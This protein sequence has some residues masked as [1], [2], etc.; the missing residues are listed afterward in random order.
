MSRISRY[1]QVIQTFA[2]YGF[3]DLV[4]E[5]SLRNF[6]KRTKASK[7][8]NGK[9]GGSRAERIRLLL[10]ELGPTYVKLGQLLSNRRDILPEEWIKEL[11]HLQD[12]VEPVSFAEVE[13][14]ID[15]ELGSNRKKLFRSID[16]E[17]LA[18][19]SIAQVHR[20]E[21]YSGEKVVLK[22][23]RPGIKATIKDDFMIIRDVAGLLLKNFKELENYQPF[24]LIDSFESA[25]MEEL[26][27]KREAI[28][29]NRFRE[30]FKKDDR[31]YVPRVYQQMCTYKLICMEEVSGTK[32]SDLKELRDKHTEKFDKLAALG[33]DLYFKQIF[34]HGFFHA[35]PHPGNV[36]ILDDGRVCFLDFGIMGSFLPEEQDDLAE[37][38]IHM[39]RKNI[40]RVSGVLQRM[41]ISS[42]IPNE[43]AFERDLYEMLEVFETV[44]LDDF[45]LSDR[46]QRFRN[47]LTENTIELSRNYYLL[48]RSMAVLEGVTKQLEP[49]YNVFGNLRH[50]AKELMLKRY[51]PKRM[52]SRAFDILEEGSIFLKE[53]PSDAKSIVK[54]MR[55]GKFQMEFKHQNLGDLY[56]TFDIVSNRISVS[57][58]VAALI[59]G[60]SLIVLAN[61]PPYVFDN[62]PIIGFIGFVISGLLGLWLVISILRH[63]NL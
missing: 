44:S 39:S 29:I 21:L 52:G 1:R 3:A 19:A 50:Y 2:K 56:K 43:R 37:L 58:L 54:K 32:I 9:H 14:V 53:L 36:F 18:S 42:S 26:N 10:Q 13:K 45:P 48:M 12:E 28:N 57:I 22:I 11:E 8:G 33:T 51:H 62:V 31:I 6:F 34:E 41:A 24:R 35:D 5:R 23:Q 60:S 25:I 40:S 47:I 59:I 4:A 30:N 49:D 27:F 61:I 7:H 20:A 17:A 55:E 63:R 16:S 15:E 38:M 46:I